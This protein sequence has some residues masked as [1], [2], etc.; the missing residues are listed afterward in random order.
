MNKGLKAL[1]K[2]KQHWGDYEVV[3][4]RYFKIIKKELKEKEELDKIEEELGIDL[5]TLF[6][7]T[8]VWFLEKGS[9]NPRLAYHIHIDLYEK[10]ACRYCARR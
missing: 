3:G 8:S 6:K 1:D 9:K 10:K 7:A 2:I 4:T 5:I